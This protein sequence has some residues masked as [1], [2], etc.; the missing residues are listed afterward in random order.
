[1]KDQNYTEEVIKILTEAPSARQ[2]LLDN[3]TNLY[4]VADYC[5]KNYLEVR[6]PLN[7][8]TICERVR[9]C[10]HSYG[11]INLSVLSRLS[12]V[13]FILKVIRLT[14]VTK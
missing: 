10:H 8:K 4:N 2:A 5:E 1:M 6:T 14:Y 7:F 11:N 13:K 9:L 12:S 3:Y